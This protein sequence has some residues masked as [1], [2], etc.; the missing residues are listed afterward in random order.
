MPGIRRG[1]RAGE[2]GAETADGTC[3]A[4]RRLGGERRAAVLTSFARE[5]AKRASLAIRHVAKSQEPAARL[6][7]GAFWSVSGAVAGRLLTVLAAAATARI[8]GRVGFGAFGLVQVTVSMIGVF[9]GFGAGAAATVFLAANR[10]RPIEAARLTTAASGIAIV[11]G[12]VSSA[13][14]VVFS[15]QLAS[16][17]LGRADLADA[18]R[19]GAALLL[20]TIM[21]GVCSGLLAGFEAFRCIGTIATIAAAVTIPLQVAGAVF[22]GVVGA[23]AGSA[24]GQLVQTLLLFRSYWKHATAEGIPL[25]ALPLRSDWRSALGFGIPAIL[26]SGPVAL[27]LWFA[28]RLLGIQENGLAAV[29]ELNAAN[30]WRAA[31]LFVPTHLAATSLPVLSSLYGQGDTSGLRRLLRRNALAAAGIA[32]AF[33]LPVALLAEF[34]MRVFGSEFAGGGMTL[35]LI[36]G[37]AVAFAAAN[38]IGQGLTATRHLWWSFGANA[39]WGGLQVALTVAWVAAGARGIAAGFLVSYAAFLCLQAFLVR[40]A[41]RRDVARVVGPVCRK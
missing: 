41:L 39:A 18:L 1:E 19:A 12:V 32:A 29:A 35:R 7:R 8:L 40:F 9:A 5:A 37:S 31:M 10:S 4:R 2:P 3:S 27:T 20:L 34:W 6:M 25:V 11:A 24:A 22:G 28:N 23:I 36:A 33:G 21:T 38:A 26:S 30:T 14:L 17:V 15:R 16:Q 13:T